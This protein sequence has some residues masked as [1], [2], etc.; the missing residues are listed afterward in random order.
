[1]TEETM[2]TDPE[3]QAQGVESFIERYEGWLFLGALLLAL[4]MR[5]VLLG[6]HS[7]YATEPD[8]VW[9]AYQVS[10]GEPMTM[11]GHPAYI[12]LTGALFFMFGANDLFARL[13]PALA[14]SAVVLYPFL[15]RE[16]LGQKTALVATFG[17]ALDPIL[18][19]T[20][21]QAGSP[22]MAIGFL[23]MVWLC[24]EYKRPLLAGFFAG[25]VLMSG[26]S[27]V[28][29]L[30]GGLLVW[31][32]IGFFTHY[33]ITFKIEKEDR[34]QALFGLGIAL[35]TVG[36]L[37][38]F[39]I[40]GLAAMMQAVPD[41][42]SL[43]LSGAT[44]G[45][46]F[47]QMLLAL[48]IYQPL[49]LLFV[50][51]VWLAPRRFDHAA[52]LPLSATILAFM[53]L[54]LLPSGRQVWMLVWALVPLWMLAA[55]VVS[56][57]LSQPE[58]QDLLLVWGE[59]AFYL[60]LLVYWWL[61]LSKMTTQFAYPTPEGMSFWQFVTTDVSARLFYIRLGVTILIPL[62]ILVMSG[63]VSWG[64]SGDASM[65]GAVWAVAVFLS[66]HLVSVGLGFISEPD[67]IANE[68]WAQGRASGYT[69]EFLTAVEE[70]SVQ[71]TGTKNLIELS[72]QVDT[73][74][75]RWLLRDFPNVQYGAGLASGEMAGVILNQDPSFHLT[76]LGQPYAGQAHV[77]N[78]R[79]EWGVAGM[80]VDFDRWLV[81]RE[82]PVAEERIYLWTRVDLFPLYESQLDD[83]LEGSDE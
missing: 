56:V 21:R 40:Q 44:E 82:G 52:T 51:F 79:P 50:L 11:I 76:D 3:R 53:I 23:A 74:Q 25:L 49:A 65:R 58:E 83:L 16:K 71:V 77:L 12:Q 34:N 5:L 39:E 57:F 70:I 38:T 61:N 60:I 64:W 15:L 72:A 20:S 41:F 36:T 19:A 30:V 8:Y 59:F 37:F 7:P 1:M 54:A 81:Y 35:V 68:L 6:Q 80:P 48:P 32:L 31:A 10:Q 2:T 63:L 42:I 45:L 73:P 14:G 67:Q 78:L 62:L 4:L 17:L 9:Q 75:V 55:R 69:E 46:T 43:W 27:F 29:G 22:V 26:K 24:W 13:I 47:S 33:E 18:V 66:F 28:F